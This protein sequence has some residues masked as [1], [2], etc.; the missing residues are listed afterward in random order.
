MLQLMAYVKEWHKTG[1]TFNPKGKDTLSAATAPV[2][3]KE[4][5]AAAKPTTSSKPAAGGLGDLKAGL[6]AFS[7]SGLKKVTKDMQTW[8][9]EYKG[10][11]KSSTVA[12]TKAP[13]PPKKKQQ[14]VT[15]GPP[16]VEF[17]NRGMKWFVENQTKEQGVVTIEMDP[18]DGP[19]HTVYIC[20][21]YE[22]T[23]DVKGKCKGVA[24][25]ACQKCNVLFDSAISSLEVVNS[26]SMKCQ[27]RGTVPS[28]AIDKTDGILT[29]LSKETLDITQFV[30]SKS[31]DMQ[32]SFPNAA[33]DMVEAPIPEQFVHKAALGPDDKPSVS[34][35]V[36][37]LYSH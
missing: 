14:T 5:P 28:V 24:V 29:Y 31:S 23:I 19:K 32:I 9:S 12:T 22:A 1:T 11:K 15:K 33:G 36:S 34:S 26:K 35:D 3:N 2:V 17:Q 13:V 30:T 10:D 37:D 8:R 25:D 6:G 4:E 27:A 21:C 18:K 7:T 16:V 20:N